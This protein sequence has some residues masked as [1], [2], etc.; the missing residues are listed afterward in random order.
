MICCA[1]GETPAFKLHMQPQNATFLRAQDQHLGRVHVTSTKKR[2]RCEMDVEMSDQA[3]DAESLA[4]YITP[5]RMFLGN[6]SCAR[7]KLNFNF[8]EFETPQDG[9][10]NVNLSSGS[11]F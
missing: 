6:E 1:L 8:T 10:F 4:D 9:R 2:G 5:K 7:Q 3:T 11:K